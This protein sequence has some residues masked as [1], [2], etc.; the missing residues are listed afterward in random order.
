MAQCSS[1]NDGSWNSNLRLLEVTPTSFLVDWNG[2][3]VGMD[4]HVVQFLMEGFT[5]YTIATVSASKVAYFVE[6]IMTSHYNSL[7]TYVVVNVVT[8]AVAIVDCC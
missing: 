5:S 3:P 6:A 1:I 8:M 4:G 2:D 7:L